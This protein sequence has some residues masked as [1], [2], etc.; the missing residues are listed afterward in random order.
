MD[1]FLSAVV[2]RTLRPL[3]LEVRRRGE[4]QDAFVVQQELTRSSKPIIFD[5][6]AAV[7]GV[8]ARYRALFPGSTIHAFEPFPDSFAQ[9]QA[10]FGAC[11]S[12]KLNQAAV[13]DV[14]GVVRLNANQLSLTN[15]LLATD[16]LATEAWG[17]GVLETRTSIEVPAVTI[18]QYCKTNSIERIDI[19]KLDIQ[20]AEL[21]ALQGAATVL[22]QGRVALIYLEIIHVRTYVGQPHFEDYLRFFRETGYSMLDIYHPMHKDHRLLQSDVIFVRSGEPARA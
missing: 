15:S 20:G 22:R 8:C 1:R 4:S 7:G 9:L 3:G 21:K 19:L 17:Q 12:F 13:T 18:D 2:N 11:P 14:P 10:Q 16:P 5:V 6:G